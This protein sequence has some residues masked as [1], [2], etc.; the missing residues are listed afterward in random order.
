MYSGT[1]EMKKDKYNGNAYTD[2]RILALFL[3][4]SHHQSDDLWTLNSIYLYY[5]TKN[6][7]GSTYGTDGSLT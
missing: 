3:G 2:R 6:D 1:A 4:C 7:R 5:P